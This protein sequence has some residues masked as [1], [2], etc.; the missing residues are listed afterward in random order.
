MRITSLLLALLLSLSASSQ[1]IDPTPDD[2]SFEI[3]VNGGR[4]F[5][6]KRLFAAFAA[7]YE[8]GFTLNLQQILYTHAKPI[9]ATGLQTGWTFHATDAGGERQ[10]KR[11][12][13]LLAGL[14][15]MAGQAESNKARL[16]WSIQGRIF[17][18]RLGTVQIQYIDHQLHLSIGFSAKPTQ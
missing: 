14:H 17:L 13:S 16:A 1:Y 15:V 7:G 9:S 10:Q 12:F 18:K 5:G 4:D 2:G 11:L 3:A 8:N 6:S